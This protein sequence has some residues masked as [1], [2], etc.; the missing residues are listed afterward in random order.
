MPDIDTHTASMLGFTA[1]STFFSSA[2][3]P[4]RDF[5][6]ILP[7]LLVI[8][9]CK[10]FSQGTV[11]NKL[12]AGYS[13][14]SVFLS[15]FF[16]TATYLCGFVLASGLASLGVSLIFFEYQ[17]EPFVLADLGYFLLSIM[18]YIIVYVFLAALLSFLCVA[19]KNAGLTLVVYLAV[20]FA[21]SLIGGIVSMVYM[22]DEAPSVLLKF[23]RNSNPFVPIIG[24]ASSYE[25][26]EVVQIL[27]LPVLLGAL[28][29][30]LGIRVFGKKD[31]K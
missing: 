3:A 26:A 13:R 11:R 31:L 25:L 18:L 1:K 23:L 6:F 5:G 10:D 21:F 28:F 8:V 16:T 19:M 12:I 9:L 20:N 30:F 14:T 22:F 17:A 7:V 2:M 29:V 27:A 24:S 4:G 15:L